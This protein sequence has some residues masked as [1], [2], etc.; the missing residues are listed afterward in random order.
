FPVREL[1]THRLTHNGLDDALA[2]TWNLPFSS[3]HSAVLRD[4][5]GQV[6][7]DIGTITDQ[8][9]QRCIWKHPN[10]IRKSV[11]QLK[12]SRS[13]TSSTTRTTADVL[14]SAEESD[15][16]DAADS[17]SCTDSID[18]LSAFGTPAQSPSLVPQPDS[19]PMS[20]SPPILG[21]RSLACRSPQPDRDSCHRYQYGS[22][23]ITRQPR[24]YR[25][26]QRSGE[27]EEEDDTTGDPRPPLSPKTANRVL[28]FLSSIDLPNNTCSQ[29]TIT[30][31][32]SNLDEDELDELQ[33]K[34]LDRG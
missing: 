23:Q 14:V 27:P 4:V 24:V 31:S 8:L 34:R 9:H 7:W 16:D 32:E 11:L 26:R 13:F 19:R 25:R 20:P 15:Y 12:D 22:T 33:D 21:K 3:D 18:D 30:L 29:S 2:T 10:V 17:F 6:G 28:D 5:I 1:A